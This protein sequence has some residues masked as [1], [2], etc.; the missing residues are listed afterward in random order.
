M[1][2]LLF[3]LVHPPRWQP[4]EYP[5]SGPIQNKCKHNT[6]LWPAESIPV[7]ITAVRE[8]NSEGLGSDGMTGK[9]P[10]GMCGDWEVQDTRDGDVQHP[11]IITRKK[12]DVKTQP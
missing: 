12:A 11:K 1:N 6:P 4:A 2:A 5:L 10:E 9:K 8:P 7:V 3:F